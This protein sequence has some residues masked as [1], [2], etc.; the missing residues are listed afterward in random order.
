GGTVLVSERLSFPG[1]GVRFFRS[2]RERASRCEVGIFRSAASRRTGARFGAQAAWAATTSG[3][4]RDVE[5]RTVVAIHRQAIG[6][7]VG[8]WTEGI[9]VDRLKDRSNNL[10]LLRRLD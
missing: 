7:A 2:L 9:Q 4:V 10:H 5:D 3:D 1:L 8:D 6:E